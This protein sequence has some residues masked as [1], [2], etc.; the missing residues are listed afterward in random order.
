MFV[1]IAHWLA[2]VWFTIGDHELTAHAVQF[3]WLTSLVRATSDCGSDHP[4]I[5]H[6]PA[7]H[8]RRHES[9]TLAAAI[10]VA[11]CRHLCIVS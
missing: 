3:G 6:V 4:R 10:P 8:T 9:R 7:E 11:P 2:C 5:P 1:L